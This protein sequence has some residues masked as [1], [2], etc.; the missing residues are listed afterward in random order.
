MPDFSAWGAAT[1]ADPPQTVDAPPEFAPGRD[2]PWGP[3]A[4]AAQTIS[5]QE[6]EGAGDSPWEATAP[7]EPDD[8][9]AATSPPKAKPKKGGW[10]PFGK[11]K[12]TAKKGTGR[13]SSPYTPGFEASDGGAAPDPGAT[14]QEESAPTPPTPTPP[15]PSPPARRNDRPGQAAPGGEGDLDNFLEGLQ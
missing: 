8:Q 15:P 2:M 7:A 6:A 12:P 13:S 4:G 10:W 5:F 1:T 3:A 11:G 9:P 14:W